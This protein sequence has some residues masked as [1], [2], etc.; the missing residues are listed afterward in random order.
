MTKRR[1]SRVVGEALPGSTPGSD[2]IA[3]LDDAIAGFI[4]LDV[5]GLCLQWRNH[6]GGIPPA[7]L[8]RW[9]L[10]RILA[11]RVQVGALGGLD[12]ETLL[13][14]RQ[15]KGHTL[16]SPD[17][18]P[19][20]ARIPTTRKGARLTAGALLAREWNG[21]LERVMV[22]ERG[23]AWNGETWELTGSCVARSSFARTSAVTARS[24]SRSLSRRAPGRPPMRS[25]IHPFRRSSPRQ[26]TRRRRCW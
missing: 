20:E 21:N 15:P 26:R 7:H 9:L 12:K 24:P 1:L 6:L 10:L 16:E 14:L 2:V 18:R 11:Y 5:K 8:P 4:D 17:E 13:I 3:S 25:T 23:F 22:L 19:F